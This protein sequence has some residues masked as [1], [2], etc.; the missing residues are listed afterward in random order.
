MPTLT[1]THVRGTRAHSLGAAVPL[2]CLLFVFVPFAKA[3]EGTR[4]Q[5]LSQECEWGRSEEPETRVFSLATEGDSWLGSWAAGQL[6]FTY[7]TS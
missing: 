2:S 5:G 7:L 1:H 6:D 3:A 4:L